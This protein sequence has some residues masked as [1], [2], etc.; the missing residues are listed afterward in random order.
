MA[1]DLD[2]Y[3]A[4]VLIGGMEPGEVVVTNYDSGWPARFEVEGARIRGALG[5][6]ATRIEHV[7]STAVPGLAAKP[8]IDI[9]V[10]VEDS[11]REEE[12]VPALERAGYVLRVREPDFHAHRMLRTVARDVHVHI[13]SVGSSEVARLLDFRDWLRA[14][15]ADRDLYAE[16][17]R[18]LASR[19]WKSMQY[20]AEA[21][22]EVIEAIMA[23]SAQG[24]A[25]PNVERRA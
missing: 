2:A 25:Q 5:D 7:G 9:L 23:R 13:Y 16:R 4:S 21:K 15:D 12:Y 20:Y 10:V 18:A 17:K 24:A 22:T 3:L 8:I 1:E 14:S 6:R 11:S 19:A